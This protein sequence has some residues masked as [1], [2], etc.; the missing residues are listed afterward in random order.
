[1]NPYFQLFNNIHQ[2]VVKF[3]L[4]AS[5]RDRMMS[6][7]KK[8]SCSHEAYSRE[9][10]TNTKYIMTPMNVYLSTVMFPKENAHAFLKI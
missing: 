10:E 8:F 1:M 3:F 7:K 2:P 9:W 5:P 4:S 6:K